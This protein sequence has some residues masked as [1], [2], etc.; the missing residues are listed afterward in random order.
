[1]E[2]LGRISLTLGRTWTKRT[3]YQDQK[4]TCECCLSEEINLGFEKSK[5]LIR[6]LEAEYNY[7]IDLTEFQKIIRPIILHCSPI[8]GDHLPPPTPCGKP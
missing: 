3:F 7:F 6:Q 2:K 8:G 1:M 5:E 4:P